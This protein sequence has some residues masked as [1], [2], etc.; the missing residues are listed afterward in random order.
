MKFVRC[1][2][3]PKC[4]NEIGWYVQLKPDDLNLLMRLHKGVAVAQLLRVQRDP[5]LQ[6]DGVDSYHN[7]I[8]LATGWIQTVEK[9]L[10]AGEI[11]LVNSCGGV[12]PRDGIKILAEMECKKLDWPEYWPDEVIT[13]A[14]WPRGHHYYLSSNKNRIFSPEKFVR[15]DHALAVAKKYTENI[16]SNC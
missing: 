11:V 10:S 9:M 13:I 2:T 7:P 14:R 5:H 8:Q 3:H 4:P 1:Q 16:E 15:Y 12:L 6:K